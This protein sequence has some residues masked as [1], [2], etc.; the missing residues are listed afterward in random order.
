MMGERKDFAGIVK[1]I[2]NF[3]KNNPEQEY[4]INQISKEIKTRW[5]TTAKALDLLKNLKLVRERI[6]GNGIP[7]TRFFRCIN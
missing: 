7:F 5:D 2:Y 1:S 4:S 3:L 6:S